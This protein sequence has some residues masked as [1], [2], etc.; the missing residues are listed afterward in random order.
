[1][2][3]RFID[4]PKIENETLLEEL[5]KDILEADELFENVN[6]NGRKGQG[7]LGIDVY[8]RRVKN[9]EWIGVQCKVRSTNR[10][11]TE[12]E[13]LHEINDAKNFNPIISEYYLYTTLSRD[14]ETQKL[15]REINKDLKKE[16]S[17]K[18]QVVFWEDIESK[19]RLKQFETV[20]YRYYHKYFRDN[21]VLGHAIGKLI[22][23]ELQF[24]NKSDSHYEFIIGKIPRYKNDDGNK[25]DYFRGTYFIVNLLD[26]KIETFLKDDDSNKAACYPSDIEY[27]FISKIDSYRVCKWLR[28]ID[29]LDNFIY[30]DSHDYKFSIT[31]KERQAFIKEQE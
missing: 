6:I 9:S 5:A 3:L 2:D 22:N 8:A 10:S 28:S 12:E 24:D 25:V 15:E 30:D 14:S 18:F 27:A 13:L 17:F 23:L 1:M 19:L 31:E 16:K 11:F 7:Q 26:R 4:I 20:Y 21:L 29:D